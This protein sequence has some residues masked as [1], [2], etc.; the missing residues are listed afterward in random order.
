MA[1]SKSV[2]LEPEEHSIAI[3]LVV[4]VSYRSVVVIDFE[5]VE[6]AGFAS[7]GFPV[8]WVGGRSVRFRG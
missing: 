1:A 2:D 3:G 6:L 4:W 8:A 5:T 7:D